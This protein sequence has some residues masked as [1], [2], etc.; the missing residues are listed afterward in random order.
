MA[1]AV[2]R[3]DFAIAAVN[4]QLRS[5]TAALIARAIDGGLLGVVVTRCPIGTTQLVVPTAARIRDDMAAAAALATVAD[6]RL[7]TH[8][9]LRGED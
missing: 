3:L 4:D 7:F 2:L 6:I 1:M 8:S 9:L 5:F